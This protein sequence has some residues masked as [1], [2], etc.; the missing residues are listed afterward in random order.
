MSQAMLKAGWR[1]GWFVVPHQV[2]FSDIDYFGHVNNAVYLTYFENA[3]TE[4]WFAITGGTV[5]RDI[6][7]IVAHARVDFRE[8]IA[9]E[10]IEIA[11]RISEMRRT[12]LDFVYEIRKNGGS[13]IAATG[14]VTVVL[15]DW[16]TRTKR[17]ITDELRRKVEEFQVCSRDA[18]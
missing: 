5:P 9:M 2:V 10:P 11:L 13:T 7:F 16:D 1:D 15:F 12:S 4:L 17:P 6:G 3:R 14:L 18:F 8:Q